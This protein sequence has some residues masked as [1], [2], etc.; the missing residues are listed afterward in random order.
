MQQALGILEPQLAQQPDDRATVLASINARLL[1]A[2]VIADADAARKLREQALQTTHVQSSG[3]NDPRLSAL[4]V[5][6]L[7]ALGRGPEAIEIL[8][9]LWKTGYRDPGFIRLLRQYKI[10]TPVFTSSDN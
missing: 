1:L 5:Q 4:Q 2:D 9:A 7:L 3:R 6:A 8:P 10:T